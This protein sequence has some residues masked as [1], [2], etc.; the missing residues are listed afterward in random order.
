MWPICN[1][2]FRL[3]TVHETYRTCEALGAPLPETGTRFD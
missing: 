1:R 2:K 3:G